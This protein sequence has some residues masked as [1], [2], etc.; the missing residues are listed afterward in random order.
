MKTSQF[1][2]EGDAINSLSNHSMAK[3]EKLHFKYIY[4]YILKATPSQKTRFG[5]RQY[6]GYCNHIF[7]RN[8]LGTFKWSVKIKRPLSFFSVYSIHIKGWSSICRGGTDREAATHKHKQCQ[9]SLVLSPGAHFHNS[10]KSMQKSPHCL[11]LSETAVLRI[12]IKL[13][14]PLLSVYQSYHLPYKCN[15]FL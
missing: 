3:Y 2:R 13:F 7:W 8:C 10:S 4:V 11:F 1:V 15:L 12:L 6:L 9:F 14:P 5:F